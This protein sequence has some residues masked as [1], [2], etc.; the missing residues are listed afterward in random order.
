[1]T[2]RQTMSLDE[3]GQNE[4][5]ILADV[6]AI[7]NGKTKIRKRLRIVAVY[8][9]STGQLVAEVVHTSKGPVVVH[10]V[11]AIDTDSFPARRVDVRG[12]RREHGIAPFTGEPDQQFAIKG[13]EAVYV[14]TGR[15]F[16][17]RTYPGGALVFR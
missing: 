3:F 12:F 1:V 8:E 15:N 13:N 6:C 11:A 4:P 17:T 9:R 7:L 2:D 16:V 14:V 10:R 5:A